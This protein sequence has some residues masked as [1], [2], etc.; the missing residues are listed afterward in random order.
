M[1]YS[2]EHHA[3]TQTFPAASERD[4]IGILR[5]ITVTYECLVTL[6]NETVVIHITILQVT[7]LQIIGIGRPWQITAVDICLCDKSVSH[8]SVE[9]SYRMSLCLTI[10][11]HTRS[12]VT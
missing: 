4:G 9:L 7:R 5:Y 8:E 10:R 11:S 6:V 2:L 12:L 3:H 1:A